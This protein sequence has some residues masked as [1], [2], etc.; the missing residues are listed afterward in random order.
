MPDSL[1]KN[2][3]LIF[4]KEIPTGKTVWRSPSNIAL[5]KY[6]GKKPVQIP[7]NPSISFTLDKS[8]TETVVEFEPAD[9]DFELE[10]YFEDKKN[11]AFESKTR[12]FFES[13]S[14]IFPFIEQ[15]KFKIHSKNS[16]PHSA[17]IASSASGMSALALAL[18]DIEKEYFNTIDGDEF[19]KK[20]SYIA[21]LGS[22]SACRS[23]YGGLVVW[24]KTKAVANSSDLYG[25]PVTNVVHND[26]LNYHDTILLVD[27]GQKKVSSRAG[28]ALME[29]NIYAPARFKQANDNLARITEVLKSGDK[30]EFVKI[31]ESE[32]LSLHAMM[33][34]SNPYYLL[35]KPGTLSIIDKV[36]EFRNDTKIPVCFTLDAGPNVHLLYPGENSVD[37]NEFIETE[38]SGFVSDK[39]M[40]Y[41]NVGKG[42]EKVVL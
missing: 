34:T 28:H 12:K 25:V 39:G 32:A 18:C 1:Y 38:L 26:F 22:G 24:G 8:F 6:W 16:F 10:F 2:H 30:D 33:M 13:I 41:D 29:S 21:R 36:F 19:Y 14:D 40:I 27:S 15:L 3:N 23:V 11:H 9:K 37:V 7:M 17:G 42:P 35:M 4:K 20:A 5:V 31:T